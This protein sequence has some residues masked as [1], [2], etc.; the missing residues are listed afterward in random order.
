MNKQPQLMDV[1]RMRDILTPHLSHIREYVFLNS[2]MAMIRGDRTVFSLLMLQRPPFT[3]NDHRF[4]IIMSGEAEINFNLQDR[5]LKS[6]TLVYVGPGTIIHPK[7]L[8]RDRCRRPSTGRCA[9]FNCLSAK[10]TSPL[11]HILWTPS[12]N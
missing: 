9:T 8:R 3:I 5:H 2:E 7:R 1:F 12:G 10:R 4:G 6:G 11:P